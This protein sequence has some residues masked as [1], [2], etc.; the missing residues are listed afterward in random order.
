M[1]LYLNFSILVIN[2]L[3][4]FSKIIGSSSELSILYNSFCISSSLDLLSFSV[5]LLELNIFVNSL[6]LF[7]VILPFFFNSSNFSKISSFILWFFDFIWKSSELVV[8]DTFFCASIILFINTRKDT[9]FS[10]NSK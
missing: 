10:T 8:C 9:I 3:Y 5:S 2:C 6:C 7:S 1:V 4:I